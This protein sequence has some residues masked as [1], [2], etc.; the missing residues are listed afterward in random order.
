MG[1]KYN[2]LLK[3][4]LDDTG[5]G[6]GGGGSGTVTDVSVVTAN[7]VSGSVANSTTTPAI[8]LSLGA[9]TPTSVASSGS[10]SGS[11]LSGTNTGDQTIELTGDVT[12][13]GTGSFAATIANDAV[14]YAKMQ[15]VSAASKL[16][17]RGDSGS[18]DAQEITIGSG[19]SMTGTTLS[20]SGINQL[21]GDVTAGPGSGSQVATIA[22]GVI[23]D[24]KISSS[25]DVMINTITF[26]IDGG[27]SAIT[28][29]VKGD[30]EITFNC[31]I[32]RVTLLADQS[33]SIVVDIWKDTYLNYPPTDADSITASAP[34]TLSSA[35]KSQDSTLTGW[36]TT[37]TAGDTLRFNVDSI[38]TCTR[39][40]ISLKVT[41]T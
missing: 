17:G 8:T 4:G 35:T 33:G 19:L 36:T 30:L 6:G 34:P 18:G 2:P 24:A 22:N 39:V 10:V 40:T 25:A 14:T 23:T 5:S 27:G 37:I 29:G 11:N 38:T 9:I 20:A 15:N 21:T 7:G 12:G 32:N 31:T 3:I 41:K 13:S 1:L 16:L 28:T 26:I